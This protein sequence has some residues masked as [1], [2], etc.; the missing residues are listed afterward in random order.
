[1]RCQCCSLLPLA[2]EGPGMRE[3]AKTSALSNT[4]TPTLSRK[5]ERGL[6]HQ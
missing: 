3:H 4:L 5:R 2:G 6:C 1:M